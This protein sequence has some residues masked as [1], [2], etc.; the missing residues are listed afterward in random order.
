MWRSVRLLSKGPNF[1][2]ALTLFFCFTCKYALFR[3]GAEGIRTPDLRRAKADCPRP[4]PFHYIPLTGLLKRFSRFRKGHL[5]RCVPTCTNPVA[6]RLQYP[7]KHHGPDLLAN[8]MQQRRS[9]IG[10]SRRVARR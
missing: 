2:L 5:Y 6:V 7:S 9:K 3:S 10:R 1:D 4:I 8:P